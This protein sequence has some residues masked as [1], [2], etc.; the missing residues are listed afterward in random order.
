MNHQDFYYWLQGCFELSEN[1]D[2]FLSGTQ[3][4]RIENHL[5]LVAKTDKQLNGFAAWLRGM[6][7]AFN[8]AC[9]SR[10]DYPD[11]LSFTNKIRDNLDE[12]FKHEVDP[13]YDNN[14]PDLKKK[15]NQIH[16]PNTLFRC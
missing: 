11:R 13:K 1:R 2:W 4:K 3:L 10:E 7:D 8:I 6:I 5:D 16:N 15:L 9:N 12:C 14:N